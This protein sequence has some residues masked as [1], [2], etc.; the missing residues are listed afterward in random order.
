MMGQ[1]KQMPKRH[2]HTNKNVIFQCED[3][4]GYKHTVTQ[5]NL[6]KVCVCLK[7]FIS[8]NQSNVSSTLVPQSDLAIYAPFTLVWQ[9]YA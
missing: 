2:S 7:N 3:P 9:K 6:L 1:C 5:L 4:D 8:A